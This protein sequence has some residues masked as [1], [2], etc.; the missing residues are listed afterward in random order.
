MMNARTILAASAVACSILAGGPS[1]GTT[2]APTGPSAPSALGA[3]QD[4]YT[5]SVSPSDDAVRFREL[6]ATVLQRLKRSS[7]AIVDVDA[8]ARDATRALEPL[9]PWAGD[10]E[11]VFRTAVDAAAASMRLIDPYFRYLDARTFGNERHE[12]AAGFGGLGL[13]VEASGAGVRIVSLIPDSP[14][15]RANVLAPGDVIVRVDDEPLAGMPLAEVIAR[16]RGQP[17]TPV[18]I[19]VQRGGHDAEITVA[20]KRD[21]IRRQLLRTS[22]EGDVLVLRLA[23]FGP[24][25]AAAFEQA[26]AQA[27]A[28][29]MPK[30][31]VLD[32]RGNPGGLLIEAVK[33]ADAFMNAGEIASLRRQESARSRSWQ[34]DPAELLPGVPMVVL[35]DRRSA[36]ASEL[37]ADALQHHGRAT[38]MGQRSFGKGSVQTTLPLGHDAGAIRLTT[39]LYHGPSGETVQRIG[40]APDIEL[41]AMSASDTLR[42][43]S[44]DTARRA[45]APEPRKVR[46][47]VDPARCSGAP[48]TDPALACAIDFFGAGGFDA[49]VARRGEVAP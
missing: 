7:S 27:S 48:A 29:A 10:P 14:A 43:R 5:R 44:D 37:V 34:S 36:S 35:I 40:V 41:V 28:A 45:D 12:T 17:G 13:Q 16:M 24:S 15:E 8:L 47:R 21:T 19:T 30:A 49:F 25:V 20:L 4:A 6:L 2:P 38:V 23:A 26:I 32:L 9:A 39:A 42:G 33:V 1:W 18:S 31:V 22:M 11:K 3:L 46:A